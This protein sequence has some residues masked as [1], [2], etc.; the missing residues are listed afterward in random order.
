MNMK[1]RSARCRSTTTTHRSS[2]TTMTALSY[3]PHRLRRNLPPSY[4]YSRRHQIH[5]QPI[6]DLGYLNYTDSLGW[7]LESKDSPASTWVCVK[8]PVLILPAPLHTSLPHPSE[9]NWTKFFS[10]SII[11]TLL[12]MFLNWFLNAIRSTNFE[13]VFKCNQFNQFLVRSEPIEPL[14]VDLGSD[15]IQ[16]SI[17]HLA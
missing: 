9:R 3:S 8:E 2:S 6:S 17:F 11:I 14:Q 15:L 16:W 4:C 13:L 5:R 1:I 10:K 12:N 7:P